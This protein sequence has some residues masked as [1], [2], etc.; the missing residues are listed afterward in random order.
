MTAPCPCLCGHDA[1]LHATCSCGCATYSPDYV[2]AAER[3]GELAALS[4]ERAA[5]RRATLKEWT[6][7]MSLQLRYQG[8]PRPGKRRADALVERVCA[9][10]QGTFKGRKHAKT[11]SGACRQ[12]FSR[13]VHYESDSDVLMSFER[14]D[15]FSRERA[16]ATG[17]GLMTAKECY[18][19]DIRVWRDHG[20]G[21][22]D[23]VVVAAGSPRGESAA[24]AAALG[25]AR[26]S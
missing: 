24:E 5:E 12:A 4:P 14:D 20:G 18:E 9:Y 6:A 17:C 7:E 1:H 11:C 22:A 19:A 25:L 21:K 26:G 2:L 16:I 8:P 13:A 15:T 23:E 3:S 10:C